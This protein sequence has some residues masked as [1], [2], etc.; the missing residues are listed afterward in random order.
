MRLPLS[1]LENGL[2]QWRAAIGEEHVSLNTDLLQQIKTATFLTHQEVTAS[3][4][5][6]S[7]K[8]VQDCLRI[9]NQS[10][11]PVYPISSGK[12][13]GYGSR[14][15]PGDNCA[16]LDLSRLNRILD[17]NDELGYVT[18]EPGVTQRQLFTFLQQNKSRFWMDATGS[19]P[20]TSLIGNCMERGFGHTPMG[21]RFGQVCGLEVVLPTGEVLET[22]S[23]RFANSLTAPVSRWGVGPSLDGLFSQSNLG[24]V[25][26]MTIWLMPI[27]DCFEAF[28]FRA[29]AEESLPALINALRDLRLRDVLRSSIHVGNDYKVLAGLQQYPWKETGAKTPLQPEQ[30]QALRKKLGFGSW[31]ASGGIYGSAAQ[32]AES[33]RLLQIAVKG[34]GGTLKFLSPKKL[35]MAKRW[36]KPFRLVSGWD[37]R[38]TVEIVEP[39][40]GLMQGIPTEQPL[41][42]A[43]WR[44]RMAIPKNPDPDRD[45]CGLLWYAPVS[46]ANGEQVKVLTDLARE[47]LLRFGFEPQISLTLLTPRTV[48]C[49]VSIAYDR[50]IPGEDEQARRC[51]DELSR[52]CTERGYYPYRLSI[53]GAENVA[54]NQ[55]YAQLLRQL[56]DA[57]DP[58]GIL[59]PGRYELTQ[60]RPV[61]QRSA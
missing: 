21:D 20:D 47:T 10:H 31:S 4:R 50:D 14:V 55:A 2:A 5:P 42:S 15:P 61:I 38:R 39:V 46:P 27:P 36:A 9:A 25:T 32:V 16:I 18:V 43:Y 8:Q 54:D 48:S 44:K 23:A 1:D 29:K 57:V 22:G 24:I 51:H 12:N 34:L 19:S 35:A 41:A 52:Q 59:A 17:F 37:L 49:I 45:R 13:W 30:M 60:T 40:M 11:L 6:G 56:K 28:F 58:N 3:I 7:R 26:R 33:K 53:L